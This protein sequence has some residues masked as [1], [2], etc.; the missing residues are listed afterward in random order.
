MFVYS[1]QS[2][3]ALKPATA[4]T[5]RYSSRPNLPPLAAIARLLVAAERRGTLVRHAVEV[6]VACADLTANLARALDGARRNVTGQTIRRIAA[7]L[8]G[9]G[10]SFAPMMTRTGPKISSGQSSC[11]W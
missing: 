7:D 9:L 8:D 6:D 11:R 3:A 4:F 5:S 2:Q 10:S 1:K